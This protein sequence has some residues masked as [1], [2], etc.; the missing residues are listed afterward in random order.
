ME[1]P[2][3]K[4]RDTLLKY[5]YVLSIY[6]IVLYLLSYSEF[7]VFPQPM[8]NATTTVTFFA[9]PFSLWFSPILSKLKNSTKCVN[10]RISTY[11]SLTSRQPSPH[12]SIGPDWC[13]S[14]ETYP[15]QYGMC[16]NIS[17]C[18]W[19]HIYKFCSKNILIHSTIH[20]TAWTSPVHGKSSTFLFIST[21]YSDS[22]IKVKSC[23]EPPSPQPCPFFLQ[24]QVNSYFSS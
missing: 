5:P 21:M 11:F 13:R 9:R 22:Y 17:V 24:K 18:S 8:S 7:F 6:L 16:R 2:N 12:G 14:S 4:N 3:I 10:L 15:D 1:C 19:K 20:I 23:K